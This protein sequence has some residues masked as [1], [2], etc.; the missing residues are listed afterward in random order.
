MHL[1]NQAPLIFSL[2]TRS[3]LGV[4]FVQA[5]IFFKFFP[6]SFEIYFKL[7]PTLSSGAH[8]YIYEMPESLGM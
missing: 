2:H 5:R 8:F 4:Q 7:L 6:N 3:A 1:K